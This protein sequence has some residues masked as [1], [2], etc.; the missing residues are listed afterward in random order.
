MPALRD[1]LARESTGAHA[2][3]QLLRGNFFFFFW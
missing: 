3:I 1:A 2:E